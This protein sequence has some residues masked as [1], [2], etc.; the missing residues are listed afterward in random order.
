MPYHIKVSKDGS[1]GTVVVTA[2]GK[3]M[4]KKALPIDRAH[5][6]MRAI[7]ANESKKR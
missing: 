4:S 1:K 3:V 6:Q 5:A 2:T 7:Y